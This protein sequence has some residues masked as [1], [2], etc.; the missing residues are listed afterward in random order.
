LPA[1]S[2]I[3]LLAPSA[4]PTSTSTPTTTFTPTA[5]QTFTP[6]LTPTQ[7]Y[8][9]WRVLL[10]DSFDDN[11]RDW[12]VGE[13]TY[14]D[15]KDVISMTNG[16]YLIRITAFASG[17]LF[18]YP[19]VPSLSNFYLTV[20]V[21]EKT[22]PATTEYGLVFRSD[23]S[24]KYYLSINAQ[25]QVYDL[26]FWNKYEWNPILDRLPSSRIYQKGTNQIAILA[27]DSLF[28]FFINGEEVNRSEDSI[29]TGIVGVGSSYDA[30]DQTEIAFDNFEVRVPNIS[31]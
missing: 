28:T 31:E 5:T 2:D 14:H 29:E 22:G 15:E 4:T 27:K 8:L 17:I 1:C 11:S 16:Q 23:S 24:E 26:W 10:S 3:P 12:P 21:E 7:S 20:E 13:G 30:G 19:D 18:L 25:Q 9:D 6:S